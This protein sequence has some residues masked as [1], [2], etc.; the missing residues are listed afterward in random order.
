MDVLLKHLERMVAGEIVGNVLLVLA[1]FSVFFEFVP[2]KISPLSSLLRWAGNRLNGE[3]KNRI[4]E[5][6]NTIDENEIDRIRWE[7]LDFANSCRN[8]RRHTQDEFE[9]II[10]LN[11]KY[12]A[13]LERREKTNGIIDLEYEYIVSLYKKCQEKNS[14]L[15][16]N[17][18]EPEELCAKCRL[19]N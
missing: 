8:G 7:I 19:A 4:D 5:I 14:F 10:E 13:I 15:P 18:P 12:H 9:H 1:I 6:S 3:L 17:E 2:V 16:S 11:T